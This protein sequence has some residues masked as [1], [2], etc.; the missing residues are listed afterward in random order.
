MLIASRP[1][2]DPELVALITAQQRELR[3]LDGGLDGQ[4]FPMH[5][6][7]RYLVGVRAGRAVACGAIQSRP[8]RTAEIKRMYVVPQLRGSGLGAQMLAALEQFARR[9]GHDSVCLETGSY[10]PAAIALYQSAGYHRIPVYGEY[11]TNPHSV[12]F[13][14]QLPV[15]V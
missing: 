6:D 2:P 10:L 9:T 1:Y 12:C 14:K 3:V 7:A 8:D 15:P 4:V 5:D 11:V 13:A